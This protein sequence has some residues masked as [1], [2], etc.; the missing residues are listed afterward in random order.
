MNRLDLAHDILATLGMNHDD[1][2]R[3]VEGV[4]F[5]IDMV[6]NN[7]RRQRIEKE[8]VVIGDRG[9]SAAAVTYVLPLDEDAV[10]GNR[11]FF[12]LPAP[13]LDMRMNAGVSYI[14]Y[15][16]SSGC[17]D[18]LI[19]KPFTLISPAEAHTVE[20]ITF[21]KPT[22][23]TPYYWPAKVHDG[24][25]TSGDRIYMLGPSPLLKSVEVGLYLALDTSDPNADPEEGVDF[26]PDLVYHVKRVVLSMERFA[27]LVPQERLQN[28]GRDFKV[29][30]QPLQPPQMASINDPINI[31]Q[32]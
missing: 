12:N 7:L 24:T 2:T 13:V 5:N 6:M 18:S 26:P 16:R 11:L 22:P 20:N 4:L 21:Q 32:L 9:T 27:L 23:T 25:T 14:R 31:T 10:V 15:H 28:D 17:A 1:A 30:Q 8:I 29:G 3:N 19:G